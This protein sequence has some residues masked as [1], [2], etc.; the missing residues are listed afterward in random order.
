MC[1]AIDLRDSPYLAWTTMDTGNP[2][3]TGCN[4]IL[5]YLNHFVKSPEWFK[6]NAL[7]KI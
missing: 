5:V 2:T 6:L 3:L 4:L 7:H 1:Y